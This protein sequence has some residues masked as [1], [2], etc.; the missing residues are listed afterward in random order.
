[1]HRS[2]FHGLPNREFRRG[3][4]SLMQAVTRSSDAGV[5][6][7]SP[8]AIGDEDIAAT[9]DCLVLPL[10]NLESPLTIFIIINIME[11]HL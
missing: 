8:S 1:M 7:V 6:P 5:A 11:R 3:A 4:R 10:C 2:S 9:K